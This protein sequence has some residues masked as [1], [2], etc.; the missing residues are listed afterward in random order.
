VYPSTTP[1]VS[2]DSFRDNQAAV[3]ALSDAFSD[4]V[5]KRNTSMI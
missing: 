2:T 3:G 5:V 4:L 1:V